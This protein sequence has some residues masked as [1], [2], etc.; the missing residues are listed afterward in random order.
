MRKIVDTLTI[1]SLAIG[2]II[3]FVVVIAMLIKIG[4]SYTFILVFA[5]ASF[6]GCVLFLSEILEAGGSSK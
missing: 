4:F 6:I 5:L 1:I 3:S 2:A